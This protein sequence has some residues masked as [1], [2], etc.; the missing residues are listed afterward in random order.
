MRITNHMLMT[1]VLNN[2]TNSMNSLAKSQG[3]MSSGNLVSRPSDN[4]VATG[5]I[6]SLQSSMDAQDRYAGNIGDAETFLSTSENAIADMS[7]GLTRVREL[8]L[9]GGSGTYTADQRVAMGT[10]VDEI[11]NQMVESGSATSGSQQVFGG[12]ATQT[13][14]LTRKGDAVTYHG[15]NGQINYEVAQGVKMT[16]NIDGVKLFQ[17]VTPTPV[18]QGNTDLFNTLIQIKNTLMGAADTNVQD[19]TGSLLGKIDTL[20]DNVVAMRS[21][22]GARTNRLDMA[23]SRN[24]A[25][26]QQMTTALSNLQD[27]DIA[28]ATLEYNEKAYAYQAALATG[29][30]VLTPS[31]VDFLAK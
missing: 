18:G 20:G 19:L 2:L 21:V 8:M 7:S 9:Q 5:Q 6:L 17:V 12:Y 29:A 24:V 14:T 10:E 23:K 13:Q 1:N 16:V 28:K 26:K 3:Q 4:P 11:I 27:V 25:D 31:L 22:I 30:K 15:D